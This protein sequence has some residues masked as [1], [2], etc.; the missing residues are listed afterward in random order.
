MT[1]GYDRRGISIRKWLTP[2]C[3]GVPMLF[4][5]WSGGLGIVRLSRA[6]SP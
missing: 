1:V 2:G 3:A 6:R 5:L 4:G